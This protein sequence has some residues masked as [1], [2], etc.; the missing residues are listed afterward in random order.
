MKLTE[1]QRAALDLKSQ[2]LTV[3]EVATRLGR[4]PATIYECIVR[5]RRLEA[6]TPNGGIYPG[7]PIEVL[8]ISERIR[9]V[10]RRAGIS[11]VGAITATTPVE[12]FG[13]VKGLGPDT[14]EELRRSVFDSGLEWFGRLPMK[15]HR[16]AG[17]CPDC[18][19]LRRKVRELRRELERRGIRCT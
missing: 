2:G 10:L 18:P 4:S 19:G 7:S 5:G 13:S 15:Y 6:M 14:I 8:P 12:M 11:T 16:P 3:K 17:T 9:N 1:L